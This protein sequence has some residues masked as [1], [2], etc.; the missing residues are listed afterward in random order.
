MPDEDKV[1]GISPH[2]LRRILGDETLGG[3]KLLA[4]KS[5]NTFEN[6]K[7][8]DEGRLLVYDPKVGSLISYAGTTTADGAGGGLT[9]VDNVLIDK[10]DFDGNLV[11]ITSGAYEG[12]ARDINGITTGGTVTPL[13]AFGG[14]IVEG[15]TFVI[16]G[17]RTTPAEVAAIEAKLDGASGLAAIKAVIDAILVDTSTTLE[18]KLDAIGGIV[19][20]ILEDT[21]TTLEAKLD[22]LAG[23]AVVNGTQSKNWNT[24]EQDLVSLGVATT[25]KKLHSLIVDISALTA[26]ATIDIRLYM[27]VNGV[28]RKL[29]DQPFVVGTDPDGCWIVN[30]TIGIH[31][32]LRVTCES[33]NAGD[34]GKAIAYTYMLEAQ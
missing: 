5:D 21:G 28:E 1:R 25:K 32:V 26:T 17:I 23:E 8:D 24:A 7:T 2:D 11:I 12:Q 27:K 33:D 6:I 20:D 16:V 19:A 9:L 31:D 29:Y 10:P 4:K 30:G 14:V 15:T 18:A 22:K 13:S 34:N 3:T